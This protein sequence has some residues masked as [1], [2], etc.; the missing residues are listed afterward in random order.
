M[1]GASTLEVGEALRRRRRAE[2]HDH[3][4]SRE[5]ADVEIHFVYD[6]SIALHLRSSYSRK[7]FFP[8]LIM[9]QCY[10]LSV[11]I[12]L[13]NLIRFIV[14]ITFAD[15]WLVWFEFDI[16]IEFLPVDTSSV[17]KCLPQRPTAPRAAEGRVGLRCCCLSGLGRG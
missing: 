11:T 17:R 14:P 3:P 16:A 12:S 1:A 15:N 5:H 7:I 13:C 2:G 6:L 10:F 8:R 9:H 4:S